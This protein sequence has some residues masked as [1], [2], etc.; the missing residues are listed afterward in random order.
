MSTFSSSEVTFVDPDALTLLKFSNP[1]VLNNV[2]SLDGRPIFAVSTL[3]PAGAHTKIID[4]QT[5]E[6]LVNIKKKTFQPDIVQFTH[7]YSGK[8]IKQREWLVA[9]KLE[10]GGP[11]WV[12]ETPIGRFVWKTD[13]TY[14]LALCP[15][16][17]LDH[18][19]AYCQFPTL[20]DRSIP[21]ALAL[22]RGTEPFRDEILTAFLILEQHLRIV[23]RALRLRTENRYTHDPTVVPGSARKDAR[24]RQAR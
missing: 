15:E 6:L 4:A 21:F 5:K 16:N 7:K 10:N 19:V 2:V 24:Q 14:R 9:G 18:P 1:S 20:E 12:G 23:E 8:S 11:K 17:D 3:D 13:S 22:E